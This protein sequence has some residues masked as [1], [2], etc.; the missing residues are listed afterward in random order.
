VISF[1]I[2][3]KVVIMYTFTDYLYVTDLLQLRPLVEEDQ[4]RDSLSRLDICKPMSLNGIH[5]QWWVDGCGH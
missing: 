1:L 4:L 2:C 3:A 5:H